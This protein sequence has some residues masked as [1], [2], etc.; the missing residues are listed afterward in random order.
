MSLRKLYL[1]FC[2]VVFL[3]CFCLN[4]AISGIISS[5]LKC[6][7]V[8]KCYSTNPSAGNGNVWNCSHLET[9]SQLWTSNSLKLDSEPESSSG[10]VKHLV[11][12]DS[13]IENL[14]T[15]FQVLNKSSFNTLETLEISNSLINCTK[16]LVWLL[17]LSSKII[18]PE[19]FICTSPQTLN[20]TQVFKALQL[21]RDVDAGCPE[22]C[23]C[24][25]AHVP[26]DDEYV[27]VR[28]SC[29]NLG[30]TELPQSLPA[31]VTI[32]M[33]L[34]NNRVSSISNISKLILLNDFG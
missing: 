26:K 31:N 2:S 29:N 11:I 17:E 19:N 28:I 16:Q 25:L 20:G 21:I 4:T 14:D 8:C 3:W 22:R 10:N 13:K 1:V 12:Q 34:S 30:F 9:Y 15:L 5:D 24:E 23:A 7:G 32:H 6:P 18:N 33:D 27:T